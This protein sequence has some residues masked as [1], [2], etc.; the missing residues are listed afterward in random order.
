MTADWIETVIALYGDFK[1]NDY[2]GQIGMIR[3]LFVTLQMD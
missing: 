3:R 1:G 2:C